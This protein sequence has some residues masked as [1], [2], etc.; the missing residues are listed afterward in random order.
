M[1]NTFIS[2]SREN[3]SIAVSLAKD[4]EDLGHTV[5]FDD[6]LSGG[7]LWW[8]KILESIRNCDIF[9]FVLSNDSLNS[10]ACNLEYEYANALGKTIIPVLVGEGVSPNLLPPALS[11]IQFIDYRERDCDALL[12][13]A[14]AFT[15]SPSPSSLPDPLPSP[16][17]VP[18][19]Y[20][21]GFVK[22]INT[23]SKLSDDE[24]IVLVAKLKRSLHD[25]NNAN[26]AKTLLKSLRK[27]RDLLANI[28]DEIDELLKNT[29]NHIQNTNKFKHTITDTKVS[30]DKPFWKSG[31]VIYS[32]VVVTII[33]LTSIYGEKD[34]IAE[35][36]ENK[37]KDVI[38][39][40]IF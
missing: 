13:L 23:T 20:L 33:G 24:Q 10:T 14:K 5:W 8:Q 28:A 21:G 35:I 27:R 34:E 12:H 22:Q 18:L 40:Q 4:I 36:A 15:T 25:P 7:Q 19:S 31:F 26:D 17:E 11:R 3:E 30:Q 29:T 39:N 16:P 6:E 9:I 32:M 2:Y 37:P 38:E 1:A